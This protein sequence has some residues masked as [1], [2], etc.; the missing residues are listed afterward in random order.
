MTSHT[1]WQPI[2]S[3][4]IMNGNLCGG[5][6]G[7]HLLKGLEM[8]LISRVLQRLVLYGQT[9]L[10][11]LPSTIKSLPVSD[12]ETRIRI[13]QTKSFEEMNIPN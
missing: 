9:F 2:E 7:A 3:A 6:A 13:P 4:S 5:K 11:K 1:Q 10:T 8:R 12:D